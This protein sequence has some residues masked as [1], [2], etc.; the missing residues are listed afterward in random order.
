M[1]KKKKRRPEHPAKPACL[2]GRWHFDSDVPTYDLFEHR[3]LDDPADRDEI[4][5]EVIESLERGEFFVWE[6]VVSDELDMPLTARQE[7]V[8][9]DLLNFDDEAVEGRILYI[10]E[11]PRPS[12]PW[13]EIVRKI[14]PRLLLN[15]FKTYEIHYVGVLEDWG[16]LVAA[17]EEHGKALSL[18]EG[19]EHP[20]DVVPAELRHKLW[21]QTCFDQLS[22]LGQEDELTLKNEEQQSR[23]Q[24]FIRDLREHK[25]SVEFLDLTLEKLL[26]ELV[27]PPE[28]EPI[29]V[30]MVQEQLG[31]AS[32]QDRIA[33]HL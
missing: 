13:Y 9:G 26:G 8:L 18:P 19:V 16:N 14:A 30:R 23:I 15:Q 32:K 31:L 12:E 2:E 28:D 22:G 29:F 10:D 4:I 7:E 6:A 17:L 25:E 21:L 33:V 27:M 1:S 24:W 5:E 3:S 11:I 20:V